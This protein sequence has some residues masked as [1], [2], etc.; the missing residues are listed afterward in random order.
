MRL[1]LF[2]YGTL[3]SGHAQAGLLGDLKRV[4]AQTQGKIYRLPAGYPALTVDA[5]GDVF[6][7]LVDPPSDGILHLLDVYEGVG[8]GL[9]RRVVI[10]V[11][12]GLR[13]TEAWTYVLQHASRRGRH[14]PSGRWLPVRR[15]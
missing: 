7:E 2:V 14:I 3:M 15:R 11:R 5:P 10:P 13:R 8:D 4:I 1:P 6:G 12:Y 9:Y